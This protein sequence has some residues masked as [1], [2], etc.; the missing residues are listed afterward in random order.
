MVD[1]SRLDELRRKHRPELYPSRSDLLGSLTSRSEPRFEAGMEAAIRSGADGERAL[2]EALDQVAR[3][4]RPQIVY[5]LREARGR[6]GSTDALLQRLVEQESG[7]GSVE[8]RVMAMGALAARAPVDA[9]PVLVRVLRSDPN[10]ELK[11]SALRYLAAVGD[12]SAIP[13]GRH[14]LLTQLRRP[15]RDVEG[16][17]TALA[18]LGQHVPPAT[19]E[20]T[21]L[22]RSVRRH[23]RSVH[24]LLERPWLARHWPEIAPDGPPP[25]EVPGPDVQALRNWARSTMLLP[26]STDA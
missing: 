25:P 4:R 21:D 23:W 16:R 9:V 3:T 5:A 2:V 15:S 11:D 24:P 8:L 7:P 1:D 12:E 26:N 18:Y 17:I 22:V 10:A 13:E 20:M 19:T 14:R 6:L